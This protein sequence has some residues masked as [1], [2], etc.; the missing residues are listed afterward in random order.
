MTSFTESL[1]SLTDAVTAAERAWR[2][3]SWDGSYSPLASA[4]RKGDAAQDSLADHIGREQ[5]ILVRRALV[6]AAAADRDR[7]ESVSQI[8]SEHLE[9]AG[10]TLKFLKEACV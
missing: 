2:D 8:H 1:A 6:V 3:H 5:A 9:D 10:Y 4:E 7:D